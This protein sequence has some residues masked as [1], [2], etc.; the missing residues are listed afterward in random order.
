VSL[1]LIPRGQRRMKL[2]LLCF[3]QRIAPD[4]GQRKQL[5]SDRAGSDQKCQYQ[6]RICLIVHIRNK[7]HGVEQT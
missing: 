7:L 2:R 3:G 4:P 6:K 5:E 1:R